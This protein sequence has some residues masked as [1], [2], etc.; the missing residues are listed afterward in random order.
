[1]KV[2]ELKTV[3]MDEGGTLAYKDVLVNTLKNHPQGMQLA[4]MEQVL[5][6][7]GT[8]KRA[9]GQVVLEDA[10]WEYV[11]KRLNATAW[12]RADSAIVRLVKDVRDAQAVDAQSLLEKKE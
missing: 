6:I 8:I 10:D 9:N 12:A 11:A 3:P 7:V 2:I 5:K 1:M 4:E